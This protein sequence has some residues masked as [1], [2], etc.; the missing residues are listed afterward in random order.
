MGHPHNKKRKNVLNNAVFAPAMA[1]LNNEQQAGY[2][3]S[4]NTDSVTIVQPDD[5]HTA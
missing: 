5:D 4:N 1:L 3:S 2:T